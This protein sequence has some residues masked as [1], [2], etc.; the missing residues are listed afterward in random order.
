VV[1][2][3]RVSDISELSLVPSI[4]MQDIIQTLYSSEYTTPTQKKSPY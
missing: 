2:S 1:R 4:S 3:V